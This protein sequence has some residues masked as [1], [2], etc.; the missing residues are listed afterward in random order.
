MH[1]RHNDHRLIW[2]LAGTGEG[3]S[4]AAALIREGFGVSV[5]VVSYQASLQYSHLPLES[6]WVGA[7]DG[8]EAIKSVGE[9]VLPRP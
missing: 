2:L 5:S 8:D 6:L 3:S 1:S 4:I 9:N 7:L